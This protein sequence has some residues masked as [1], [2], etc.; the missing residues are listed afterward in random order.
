MTPAVA[1]DLACEPWTLKKLLAES[2][3]AL[4]A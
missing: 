2:A 4:C 1:A 3:K